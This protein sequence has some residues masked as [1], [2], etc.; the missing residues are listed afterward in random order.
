[1]GIGGR[2]AA[3]LAGAATL[4]VAPSLA[5]QD[6]AQ[7]QVAVIG[8]IVDRHQGT[9]VPGVLVRFLSFQ[10]DDGP[11]RVVAEA[12][13]S[14]DGTF[15]FQALSV[16]RYT[17]STRMLGYHDLEER[18][19]VE[20]ASPM[21]LDIGLVPEAVELEPLVVRSVRSRVLHNAGFY[22]RRQRG[23]GRTF[24]REEIQQRGTSRTTDLLRQ[25]PGVSVRSGGRNPSPL[26]FFR[27]GCRPDI[28]VDGHNLGVDVAIDD[29]IQ[30]WTME[31]IEV[32][33]G[34]TAPPMYSSNSCGAVLIWSLDP[35]T[36]EGTPLTWRRV[37]AAAAFVATALFLTR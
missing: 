25:V 6:S 34:M 28:V 1:M 18:L 22:Q 24:T 9:P 32:Y 8:V 12:T 20:G 10:D 15:R 29:M 27:A 2:S 5:A 11:S 21:A 7:R 16:G 17:V 33:V 30:P 13:T 3:I 31:G 23:M 14:L 19:R 4:L 36:Q 35:S 37:F 26:V